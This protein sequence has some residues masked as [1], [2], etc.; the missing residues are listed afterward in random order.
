VGQG[1]NQVGDAG[2]KAIGEALKVNFSL[3]RLDLVRL[4]LLFSFWLCFGLVVLWCE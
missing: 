4:F 3:H 2:A 1:G